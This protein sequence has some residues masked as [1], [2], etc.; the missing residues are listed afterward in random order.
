MA[1]ETMSEQG[2]G[3][4]VEQEFPTKNN[5]FKV[6][7]KPAKA[8]KHSL[9]PE[10]LPSKP[11]FNPDNLS[12]YEIVKNGRDIEYIDTETQQVVGR[13]LHGLS[14][15]VVVGE[16]NPKRADYQEEKVTS[17]NQSIHIYD[18]ETGVEVALKNNQGEITYQNQEK[19]PFRQE[20]SEIKFF[21][22]FDPKRTD[23]LEKP[24]E[25]VKYTVLKDPESGDI[26]AWRLYDAEVTGGAGFIDPPA[27]VEVNT[28]E[29]AEDWIEDQ[30]RLA[31]KGAM[32]EPNMESSLLGI[33]A[34]RDF[35]QHG[36]DF[37]TELTSR[38][39][40]RIH[41][42]N[43]AYA[44]RLAAA[45]LEDE[46]NKIEF[47]AHGLI[48][49]KT[50]GVRE[51][52][53]EMEE[54]E[55]EIFRM[56]DRDEFPHPVT[57]DPTTEYKIKREQILAD[58]RVTIEA[59]AEIIS[60]INARAPRDVDAYIQANPLLT[61]ITP[62]Q[63][64][65]MIDERIEL[66]IQDRTLLSFELAEKAMH[67]FGESGYYDGIR[68]RN[69]SILNNPNGAPIILG[70][71][72]FVSARVLEEL[73]PNQPGHIPLTLEERFAMFFEQYWDDID[74]T[75]S[76]S[77]KG[78]LNLRAGLY[79]PI[80]LE[81]PATR[82]HGDARYLR[83]YAYLWVSSSL[84]MR[85]HEVENDPNTGLPAIQ[86]GQYVLDE[87]VRPSFAGPDGFLDHRD[88]DLT[89]YYDWIGRFT[90]VYKARTSFNDKGKESILNLPIIGE[91]V[92]TPSNTEETMP[93]ALGN[94]LKLEEAYAVMPDEVLY[95][96]M[97]HWLK[98][99]L[100][101]DGLPEARQQFGYLGWNTKVKMD[102]IT[103]AEN[104]KAITNEQSVELTNLLRAGRLVGSRLAA[105]SSE[106]APE[107]L[108]GGWGGITALWKLIR[109]FR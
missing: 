86:N 96:A 30:L 25:P 77:G 109:G 61:N 32:I 53:Q 84:H 57:G 16:Y 107:L 27:S 3:P 26:V 31:E 90:A 82:N 20:D 101:Y 8:F 71:K 92:V 67:F 34:S 99:I 46:F 75:S 24:E 81:K 98:G 48:L 91:K 21:P 38:T 6:E 64:Q 10:A 68:L 69:G 93:K 1:I 47:D 52:I 12:N 65:V 76:L 14:G 18:P 2:S 89:K 78:A 40:A 42:H 79:Y 60:K 45:S 17:K 11:I 35:R 15:I 106:M 85:R 28:P 23:Y 105:A 50:V 49:E 59:N 74:K 95:K 87:T 72:N 22:G 102:A 4:G 33:L 108:K 94:Y 43:T 88:T 51:G 7:V 104:Q 29:K 97:E 58:L 103:T 56:D 73:Y 70:T 41:Y 5:S 100:I 37:T 80:T 66:L 55:G 19:Y 36:K 39:R 9:T 63:K 44:A 13:Q 83:R 62:Q 54:N